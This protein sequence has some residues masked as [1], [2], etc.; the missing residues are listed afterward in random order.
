MNTNP[1][2]NKITGDQL[3]V[4]MFFVFYI[5]YAINY[6]YP[7]TAF[8]SHVVALA[9]LLVNLPALVLY[10]APRFLTVGGLTLTLVFIC[11]L[12]FLPLIDVGYQLYIV[13]MYFSISSAYRDKCISYNALFIITSYCVLLVPIWQL[14]GLSEG[15][16]KLT[17]IPSAETEFIINFG[18]PGQTM[19]MAAF[20][21][22]LLMLFQIIRIRHG[23]HH[24]ISLLITG[25]L[26][27]FTLSRS[28]WLAFLCAAIYV[29][30]TAKS[31]KYFF[32]KSI[33]ILVLGLLTIYGS[34]ILVDIFDLKN[35][36]LLRT[37]S[38]NVSSGRSFLWAWHLDVFS[39]N[40]LGVGRQ[41][42]DQF[43][44]GGLLG[45]V[46]ISAMTES[47]FTF[48]LASYGV[49]GFLN[50]F[51]YWHVFR[52]VISSRDLIKSAIVVFAIIAAA[53]SS[54]VTVP[55]SISFF[56]II[57]LLAAKLELGLSHYHVKRIS[58]A[59]LCRFVCNKKA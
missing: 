56:M 47:Y 11:E 25:Y 57:P 23:Q 21:V 10:V 22:G 17:L 55:Y 16:N 9:F 45:D 13:V 2:Q 14:L 8:L 52:N 31:Q 26:L 1:I 27:F 32:L 15:A 24:F 5:V 34:Q 4:G 3:Y 53:G 33:I 51:F 54:F 48:V 59:T 7:Q 28:I 37:S 18:A 20:L 46:L 35:I 43:E 12:I 58:Q 41:Y 42:F 44:R 50:L 49:F 39:N 6:H 40:L 29:V 19:H 38:E 36:T 30:I